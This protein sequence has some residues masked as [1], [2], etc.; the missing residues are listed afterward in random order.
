MADE[1]RI[2][3]ERGGGPAPVRTNAGPR[4]RQGGNDFYNEDQEMQKALEESKKS[5]EME[6]KRRLAALKAEREFQKAIDMSNE[7]ASSVAEKEAYALFD[8]AYSI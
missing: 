8:S 1:N 5:G 3:D 7:E 6:E 4:A 2:R